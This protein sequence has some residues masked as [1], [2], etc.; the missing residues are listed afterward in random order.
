[1]PG[2]DA[3]WTPLASAVR[4]TFSPYSPYG[5]PALAGALLF[6]AL[7]YI[8]RR[9]SRE[10]RISARG[11]VRTIFA[12]R[13][14]LHPSSLVD[15]RLWALNGIVFASTYGL[16]AFGLFFWRDRI[17]GAL[18]GA[19]GAHAPTHWPAWAVMAMATALQ[20][21]TY[22][23]AYWFGHYLFHKIPALWEFHKVH[24]SAEV[25][26]PLTE[27]RQHPVEIIVMVN[28]IGLCTGATFG[29]MTYVFGPGVQSFTLLNGNIL[30]MMFLLT[31]GHLRHSHM[32]IPFTGVAGRIL[33]SPAHHQL[34]H[35]ANPIH[36]DK[37][38]GFA[39]A[40]WDWAFGTLAMPSKTPERIVFG[41]G[42]EGAPFR[43]TLSALASPCAR[44][45][46]HAL[47]LVQRI[48][49]ARDAG[50]AART[51]P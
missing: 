5:A 39:L 36:F 31:Y 38:L 29:A 14:I 33:Q 15:L 7:Y 51:P 40:V 25:L 1:V 50:S 9:N 34:H 45:I 28:L 43:S 42:D 2:L 12:R 37:N 19:F 6:S 44:L 10:R 4:D 23:L 18:V 27:L 17:E 48:A 3:I 16:I 30:T 13:V 47:R 8:G 35:S 21:L 24:H 49:G 22:E 41:V 11:F 26:T 32:W 46:G 20:L